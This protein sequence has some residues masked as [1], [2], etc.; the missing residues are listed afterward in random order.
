MTEVTGERRMTEVTGERRL[1]VG[2]D[3]EEGSALF[4]P[5]SLT[6]QPQCRSD[7]DCMRVRRINWREHGPGLGFAANS[8]EPVAARIDT[9][10]R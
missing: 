2:F 4:G 5:L 9:S 10:P 1:N 3:A 7:R 8:V 6:P